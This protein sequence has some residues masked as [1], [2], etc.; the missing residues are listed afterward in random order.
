MAE[1]FVYTD[2]LTSIANAIRSRG[3][4]SAALAYPAGF[5]TAI[6]NLTSGCNVTA[7]QM[8]SG[9]KA[10]NS[11]NQVITGTITS[12]A[13]ATYNA[14]ESDRTI[15]AETYLSGAQ[16]ITAIT[17]KNITAG[18]IKKGVTIKVGDSSD[19]DRII[20]KTG[21][22]VPLYWG[23]ATWCPFMWYN[24]TVQVPKQQ[25]MAGESSGTAAEK[26]SGYNFLSYGVLG[27]TSK[28]FRV[29]FETKITFYNSSNATKTSTATLET[30]VTYQM[31]HNDSQIIGSITQGGTSVA[32]IYKLISYARV[33]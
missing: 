32:R 13:A 17:T 25:T 14:S 19:K 15:A 10:M 2:E 9:K 29:P 24:D 27:S 11:N 26:A 30:G 12:K 21:T 3:N 4:T 8:L 20:T 31:Q 16:T 6:N 33:T 22:M 18:N 7:A 23:A 5:V 28:A 1:Y